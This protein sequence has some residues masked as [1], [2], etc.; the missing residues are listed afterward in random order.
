MVF[1][2]FVFEEKK[3]LMALETPP[4]LMAKVI[5]NYLFFLEPFPMKQHEQVHLQ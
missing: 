4:P 3:M 5:K 1:Q 2:Q